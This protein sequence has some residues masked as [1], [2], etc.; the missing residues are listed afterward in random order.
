MRKLLLSLTIMALLLVPMSVSAN[1]VEQVRIP[2]PQDEYI[3]YDVDGNYTILKID[4]QNIQ[5]EEIRGKESKKFVLDEL[6]KLEE[7][8]QEVMYV[9]IVGLW[10]E[11]DIYKMV[12]LGLIK[13]YP[14]GTFRPN[15]RI[16][17]AEFG[18]ILARILE[19]ERHISPTDTSFKDVPKGSWFYDY[20]TMLEAEGNLDS[21]Y[22]QNAILKPNEPITREEMALWVAK[23]IDGQLNNLAFTDANQIRFKDEVANSVSTGLLKGYPDG[24]FQPKG[25]ATRAEAVTILVRLLQVKGI[26]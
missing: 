21:K 17:R 26:I 3:I 11:S 24:S 25:G 18:A 4:S 10:A 9:D 22:Y 16:T 7:P 20:L 19:K 12:E 6:Q 15:N 8:K 5:V 14:D 23:E 13:G 1:T 2:L